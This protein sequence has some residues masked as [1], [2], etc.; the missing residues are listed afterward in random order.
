MK[1][2]GYVRVSTAEQARS[3]LGLK[4][5]SQKCVKVCEPSPLPPSPRAAHPTRLTVSEAV[6]RC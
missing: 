3:G 4:A 5:Q 2:L 1:A 6:R